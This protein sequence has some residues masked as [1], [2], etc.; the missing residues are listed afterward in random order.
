LQNETVHLKDSARKWYSAASNN[1]EDAFNLATAYLNGTHGAPQD[2]ALANKYYKISGLSQKNNDGGLALAYANSISKNRQFEK[3]LKTRQFPQ[4]D[5]DQIV[6]E[7]SAVI[8]STQEYPLLLPAPAGAGSSATERDSFGSPPG[9][10]PNAE[11]YQT[12][13]QRKVAAGGAKT[14]NLEEEVNKTAG[15]VDDENLYA[16]SPKK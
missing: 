11:K 8:A 14:P 7:V 3:S 15:K 13:F 2:V 1:P 10:P 4:K 6:A 12:P 16:P 9:K 5:L